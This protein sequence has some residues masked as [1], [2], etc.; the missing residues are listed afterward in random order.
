MTESASKRNE[1]RRWGIAAVVTLASL[2]LFALVGIATNKK[3]TPPPSAASAAS[4]NTK[5]V[6]LPVQGMSCASC[7]ANVKRSLK[8]MKGVGEA[9]VNLGEGNAR[10]EYDLEKVTPELLRAKIEELGYKSGPPIEGK[11]G[12]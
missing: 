9:H 11:S 4:T 7:V 1:S 2:S 5:S 6:T 8:G 12:A 10:I 3:S